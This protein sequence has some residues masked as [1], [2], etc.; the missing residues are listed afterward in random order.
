MNRPCHEFL[1]GA[2]FRR[3][4]TRFA[5]VWAT[6]SILR[7]T[8]R[9]AVESPMSGSSSEP[10][11]WCSVR[12]RSRRLA[13]HD[14]AGSSIRQRRLLSAL[15]LS[16]GFTDEVRGAARGSHGPNFDVAIRCDQYHLG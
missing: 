14:R 11:C 13:S 2:V 16:Q 6:F 3:G 15:A 8:S 9:M 5:S 4:S 1:A 12:S 7:T 10:R